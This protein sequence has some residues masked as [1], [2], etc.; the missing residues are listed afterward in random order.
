MHTSL[1]MPPLPNSSFKSAAKLSPPFSSSILDGQSDLPVQTSTCS[2]YEAI[3]PLSGLC[4]S[5]LRPAG[6]AGVSAQEHFGGG[7]VGIVG[8][9]GGAVQMRDIW[10]A[11]IS[12]CRHDEHVERRRDIAS[13]RKQKLGYDQRILL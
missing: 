12:K 4:L 7:H 8:K 2:A 5:I 11:D 9:G 1:Y 6:I 13:C 10:R 3:V